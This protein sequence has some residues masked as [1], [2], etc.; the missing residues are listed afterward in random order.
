[1]KW[2]IEKGIYTNYL[3]QFKNACKKNNLK[4]KTFKNFGFIPPPLINKWP[5]IVILDRIVEKIP[6]LNQ[7]FCPFVL[8]VFEK[9]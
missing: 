5:F 9:G 1:M 7:V 4:L 2:K 6:V 3:E 8:M